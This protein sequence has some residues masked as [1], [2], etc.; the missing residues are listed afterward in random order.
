[1]KELEARYEDFIER[2]IKKHARFSKIGVST[3]FGT[4]HK[5]RPYPFF[6]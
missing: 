5:S 6:I 2:E 1:M 3:F 4:L